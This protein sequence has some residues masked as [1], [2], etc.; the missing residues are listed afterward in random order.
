MV[1]FSVSAVRILSGGLR[2]CWP[3]I[4]Y[5]LG[6]QVLRTGERLGNKISTSVRDDKTGS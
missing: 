6:S 4:F 3:D 2:S 1:N 5:A